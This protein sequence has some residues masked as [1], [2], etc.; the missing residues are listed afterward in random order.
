VDYALPSANLVVRG[1]GVY[2]PAPGE[3]SDELAGVSDHHLVWV[4]VTLGAGE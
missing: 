2:W 4:D 3:P 1:S